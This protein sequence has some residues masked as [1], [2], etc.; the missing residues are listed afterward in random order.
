MQNEEERIKLYILIKWFVLAGLFLFVSF[1]ILTGLIIGRTMIPAFILLA[2]ATA[3]NTSI[4][5]ISLNKRHFPLL[6]RISVFVDF[7]FL[8][9]A[10]YVNGGVENT[11]WFLPVFWVFI[12]GYLF[13]IWSALFYALLASL[14][15]TLDFTLEYFRIIP[16]IT[17]HKF[18]LNS[19]DNPGYLVDYA[20][21]MF[22]LY[23][24]GAIISGYFTYLLKK[25]AGE[26]AHSLKESE[27]ARRESETARSALLNIM[28]DLDR[29]KAD[30]EVKVRERTAELEEAK[31]GLEIKVKDRTADLEESRKALMHM[32]GTLKEDMAKLQ[33]VDKLKTEFLSMV[34]HE[35]RTPLTPIK[36]YLA[37][38]LS[39]K[40]GELTEQQRKTL[41]VVYKQS[42][43]LHSLIDNILDV[44]RMELGKPIPLVKEPILVN[45]VIEE[46][47]EAMAIQAEE[48]KINLH[49]E[50][51]PD[52]PNI[53]ADKTKLKRIL[54][55]LIGNAMK[56]TAANGEIVIKSFL[57][58]SSI[59]VDVID[60]GIGLAPDT[61]E[62]IFEKFYQVDSSMTRQVGGIGMGLP[63]CRELVQLHGGKL[64]AESE[65]LG[66]GAKLSFTLPVV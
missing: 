5:L 28:E 66:K 18:P 17:I 12:S 51:Q 19:L 47:M 38:I 58:G 23:F 37:I 46:T 9:F 3:M 6:V 15:L 31:S 36:G 25:T 45:T 14:G 10:F 49:A 29:A 56:F 35:L 54:T 7:I 59:Q 48:K 65:G 13:S 1:E 30:L 42:D 20:L 52:L 4:Y 34:S 40:I 33:V 44:A 22:L 61:I 53:M 26:L 60:N 57:K 39:G 64:W 43:H 8:A 41:D 55:N 62:K 11:W 50:L 27:S 63:I 24:I 21:G 32:M 2:L 16:H